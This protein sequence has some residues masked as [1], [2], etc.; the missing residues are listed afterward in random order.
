MREFDMDS[1]NDC[2]V[3]FANSFP[4]NG[5]SISIA[6]FHGRDMDKIR[7]SLFTAGNAYVSEYWD[8]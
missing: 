8:L 5:V 6:V 1:H 2:H 7:V 4:E 3:V